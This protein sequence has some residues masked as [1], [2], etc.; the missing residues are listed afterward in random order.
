MSKNL[1]LFHQHGY[2][3]K[4]QLRQNFLGG[5]V[6]YLGSDRKTKLPVT[7]KQFQFAKNGASWTKYEAHQQEVEIL[8][9]LNHPNIP[10]YLDE[11]ETDNGFCL[12]TE[13]K[14]FPSL[15]VAANYTPKEIKEIATGILEILV[16]L[17]QQ[18]PAIVHRDIKPENILIDRN[19]K[20]DVYLVGFGNA[21]LADSQV[22]TNHSTTVEGTLG[23]MP[24]EQLFRQPLTN[25][26]DLYSVGA[27][28][29]SLLMGVRSEDICQSLD[30]TYSFDLD[31][32]GPKLH[33]SFVKWLG[34]MVAPNLKDRYPNA[35]IALQ[36]LKPIPVVGN[37]LLLSNLLSGL[38]PKIIPPMVALA[39]LGMTAG[40]ITTFKNSPVVN[41]IAPG[42]SVMS[43]LLT[44]GDCAYCNL[45]GEQLREMSLQGANLYEANL[46]KADLS[47]ANLQGANLQMSDLEEAKLQG[48]NLQ[49]AYPRSANLA[50]AKLNGAQLQGAD[51]SLSNLK[52]AQLRGANLAGAKLQETKLEGAYLEGASLQDANLRYAYLG[53]AFLDHVNLQGANLDFANLESAFLHSSY[54]RDANLQGAFLQNANLQGATLTN[55]NLQGA[56]LKGANLMGA[57]L[58]GVN[59]KGADLRGADL[60][61]ANITYAKLRDADLEGAIM[62]DGRIRRSRVFGIRR[63][64]R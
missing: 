9:S 5:S 30:D 59:F 49:G 64:I 10:L 54:L 48:A 25:A 28:L 44:T 23:F 45:P 62:P 26:S 18:N 24:P 33:P 13:Y 55:A 32:I 20:I 58:M 21:I 6:T 8:K 56:N 17:Q 57:N 39:T 16:Y 61:G 35:A 40:L 29:I 15:A 4:K 53:F 34:K 11:F 19:Q 42:N 37:S 43:K 36:A 1:N 7:I 52:E 14:G 31:K 41:T 63:Y 27:T 60:R 22:A 2:Q 50:R 38:S 46:A 12:V 3:V 47:G 51:L